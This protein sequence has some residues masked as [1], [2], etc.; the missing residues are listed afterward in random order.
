M[1][2]NKHLWVVH[3][4]EVELPRCHGATL[5]DGTPLGVMEN[6]GAFAGYKAKIIYTWGIMGSNE[7]I[8]W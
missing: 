7:E 8:I 4:T 6:V 1:V 2:N 3:S 5:P